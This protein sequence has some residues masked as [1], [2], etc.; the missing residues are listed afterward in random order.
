MTKS[1]QSGGSGL[2][3][4]IGGLT[5]GGLGDI[6]GS[7]I[8]GGPNRAI[9]PAQLQKGLGPNAIKKL[10]AQSGLPEADVSAGLAQLLPAVVNHL[11][12]QA[13][14]PTAGSLDSALA[15]LAALLPKA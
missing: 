6:V 4:I 14:V 11:T 8:G 12:P 7:W 1:K 3:D 15:G 13:Q 10:S 2:D 5:S 9:S